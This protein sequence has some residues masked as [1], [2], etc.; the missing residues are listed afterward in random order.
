MSENNK[1]IKLLTSIPKPVL[2]VLI[3]YFFQGVIHNL[4][5]P[6]T[7]ELVNQKGIDEIYFGYF[8]A[9]MSFGLL[10]GGPIWG[11]LG[12]HGN[13]RFYIVT[14]LLVYSVGQYLFAFSGN[15]YWMILYRF[16][17]GFGVSASITLIMSHLI[18]HS[19]EEKRT[20]YLGW[21]QALFVLG[22]SAGYWI[23]GQIINIKFFV[24][25]F[26]TDNYANIF[27]IQSIL[28]VGHALVIFFLIGKDKQQPNHKERPNPFQAFKDIRRLNPNLIIFLLSLALISLG[29]I[30]L[31]KFL[32]VYLEDAEDIGNFVG[33]TGIVSILATMFI[34][35]LVVKMKKDFTIMVIIQIL[36]A[37]IIFIVFRMSNLMVALYTLFMLYIMLKAVYTPLEQ[38]Y[39][40]SH[41]P[42]GKYGTIMG[43]RQLFYSIGLVAGPLLGGFLYNIDPILTFDV[44]AIMFVLGFIILLIVGRR[45]KNGNGVTKA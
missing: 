37:V 19:S 13:K 4:G 26:H 12:D 41:A 43:V 35:P 23:A 40:S 2:Y 45:I 22:A 5:H 11:T 3:I 25:V 42:K 36:S 44:S 21:Y 10:L 32:E 7:P 18:E 6:V 17:S 27:L 33:M 1:I 39:I 14:G 15:Q 20:V 28:N 30:N 29:A 8:F 9:A 38:S 34:V 31:S 16:I 24:D